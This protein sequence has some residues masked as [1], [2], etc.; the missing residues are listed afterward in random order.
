[1]Q[2]EEDLKREERKLLDEAIE[3]SKLQDAGGAPT[4]AARLYH[5]RLVRW[6]EE[7]A[8]SRGM[9]GLVK[10]I[11]NRLLFPDRT[12]LHP[13]TEEET[14]LIVQDVC[15]EIKAKVLNAMPGKVKLEITR[16]RPVYRHL[17]GGTERFEQFGPTILEVA[18]IDYTNEGKILDRG[19]EPRKESGT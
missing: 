4:E 14:A 6:L 9:E 11:R 19:A 1:M 3:F 13:V 7:V 17:V 16:R 12:E 8:A 18:V 2:T 10:D 5:R 15:N